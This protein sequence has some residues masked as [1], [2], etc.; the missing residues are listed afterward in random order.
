MR[1]LLPAVLVLVLLAVAGG[2]GFRA[3]LQRY[4]DAP[5]PLAEPTIVYL[6]RGSGVDEITRRL[7]EKGALSHPLLFRIALRLSGR[8]RR[9]QAGEY[10]IE[11]GMSPNA[12]LDRI[13]RGLVVLHRITVPEGFTV[14][15]VYGL[16]E[17]TEFLAGEL[18]DPPPEGRLLPETYLFPRDAARRQ[19]VEAMRAAMDAALREAWE[20]RDPDLPLANEGELLT[21][22]SIVEKE[23][24]IAEEYPIVAGVFVNR[25][26]RGMRLQSD[27]TVIYA[28]TRGSGPLGRRLTRADLAIDDPYNT[29]LVAGLPPGPIANPGRAALLATARPAKVDYL[30]FVADGTGGHAFSRTLAEHN[31]KVRNWRKIR[32]EARGTVPVPVERPDAAEA[33]ADAEAQPQ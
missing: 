30:Y 17:E 1:R 5:G 14:A 3:Y 26:R 4:M 16:L 6:P 11:P 12:I 33:S 10:E 21:L 23:T 22:A 15:Q 25:L 7:V 28:I 27:P 32:D 20:G 2:Y 29:Y 13:E 8:D 18:P 9:L 31:R 19:V 24:S